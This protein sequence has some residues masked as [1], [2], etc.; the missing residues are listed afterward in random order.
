MYEYIF[1]QSLL[2]LAEAVMLLLS[3]LLFGPFLRLLERLQDGL[4]NDPNQ[5]KSCST[6]ILIDPE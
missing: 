2:W 3:S 6:T 4:I 5:Y 1:I